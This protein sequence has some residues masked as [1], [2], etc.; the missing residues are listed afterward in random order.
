MEFSFGLYDE[1]LH[2]GVIGVVGPR[3]TWL[4]LFG[5]H[6]SD[7]SAAKRCNNCALL[8]TLEET[9][10]QNTHPF[11]RLDAFPVAKASF[12]VHDLDVK[13]VDL[14]T[15]AH[16]EICLLLKVLVLRAHLAELPVCG[17]GF[18]HEEFS[19]AVHPVERLL[20]GAD[21]FQTFSDVCDVGSER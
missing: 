9:A 11:P 12:L 4:C 2:F 20:S 21:G 14:F 19:A 18:G 3:E 13:C 5:G 16:E 7:D 17:I 6:I 8:T 1:R 10:K 15:K